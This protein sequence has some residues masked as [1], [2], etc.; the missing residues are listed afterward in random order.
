MG[1]NKLMEIGPLFKDYSKRIFDPNVNYFQDGGMYMDLTDDEIE[2]YRKGGYIVEDISVPELNQ[3]QKGVIQISDPKEYAY[4]KKM[5][6]DSLNLYNYGN[7]EK[8]E[9]LKTYGVAFP[10]YNKKEAVRTL[11]TFIKNRVATNLQK[12]TKIKPVGV[13]KDYKGQI[14]IY[15]K[16]MQPVTLKKEVSSIKETP[17]NKEIVKVDNISKVT[18]PEQQES[19]YPKGYQPYRLYGRILDPEVYGYG[20][21][22]NGIPLDVAQFVD[23]YGLKKKMDEYKKSEKY[24]WVKQEGG[25][26]KTHRSKDGTITNTITKANGDT[27]IQVKTKDGKYYEK[28]KPGLPQ[29]IKDDFKKRADWENRSSG[30]AAPVDDFW[31]LP[32]GMTSAGVKG[33]GALVKGAG[34]TLAKAVKSPLVQA[35]KAGTKAVFNKAPKSLPGL[36]LNNA[37]TASGVGFGIQDY[38]DKESDVNK[39]T[40][41]AYDNPTLGNVGNA[42]SEHVLNLLNF[43]GL[44]TSNKLSKASKYFKNL[45]KKPSSVQLSAKELTNE[46]IPNTLIN[47]PDNEFILQKTP[48]KDFGIK[49]NIKNKPNKSKHGFDVSEA[50]I[51]QV[52]NQ[53]LE[54][55]NH[56]EYIKRRQAT[57][58]ES[59]EKIKKEIKDYVN[60][61]KQTE[62]NFDTHTADNSYGSHKRG[63][64]LFGKTLSKPK[65]TIN[66]SDKDIKTKHDFLHILDHEIKHGLSPVSKNTF[67][68]MPKYKNYPHLNLVKSGKNANYHNKDY[69]QQVRF[70]RMKDYLNNKYGVSKNKEITPDEWNLFKDDW[71][72]W[73]KEEHA[74]LGN[75]RVP[76]G[77]KDIRGM[78]QL[79]D[80]SVTSDDLR[81]LVNKAWAAA[82]VAVG[83][84]VMLNNKN[85]SKKS[86][87]KKGGMVL[88]LTPNEIEEYIKQGYTVEDVD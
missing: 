23:T 77:Y 17:D 29:F 34:S 46:Y 87:M 88:E 41:K 54:Y 84:A 86:K 62:F 22:T 12:N 8:E 57:T 76:R 2:E 74:G 15:K 31:T 24:P 6:N 58:G 72:N 45:N 10:N 37:L 48:V 47:H 75:E 71:N 28:V 5:Y 64:K 35:T 33:A 13:S 56:P 61:L 16:P 7:K 18:K 65:I 49:L 53:N 30:M 27:V 32:I 83:S 78:M 63:T 43:S 3:A 51:N 69:E 14:L 44:G 21:S 39:A 26:I 85:A 25:N 42:A 40:K 52:I 73:L 79:K 70:L 19:K 55:L 50:E 9:Q 60:N 36:T 1:K 4:R 67:S 81:K 20:E 80:K 82:P 11:N 68:A 66:S 59:P 38:L